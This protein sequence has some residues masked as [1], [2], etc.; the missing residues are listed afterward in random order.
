M[1]NIAREII[2]GRRLNRNDDLDMLLHKNLGEVCEGADMIR[3]SLCGNKADLCSIINGR[4][5]RCS[6]NCKFCAQSAHN[7]TNCDVHDFLDLSDIM[8]DCGK[9]AKKGVNRYSIV[10]S[11][12]A[13][14]GYDL[15]LALKAYTALSDRYPDMIFCA[16]FGL[17]SV[18]DMKRLKKAGVS[19]YH[20]NI[21]TSSRY[22]PKICTSHTYEDKIN[23][24]KRAKEA[25]LE[26]CSGGIFGMGETWQ[27]RIDMAL[28]LASFE[29]S[30][31]PL[32]FLLPIKGTPLENQKPLLQE[33]IVR[34]V[35]I[36][37]YLN[38]TAYIRIAAGRNYFQDGGAVLFRSGANAVLTGDMLTTIGSSTDYD[39]KML[40]DFGFELK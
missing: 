1:K 14:E 31:I 34:I 8:K 23:Q 18:D 12:R 27:D 30:S 29:I 16:S 32:N 2:N 26:V 21:E 25:G 20:T 19:M 7:N 33:E 9:M 5:G 13:M 22:F 24:I 28:L 10:T 35:A 17:M 39:K 37:R 4:S 15:N 40:L 38:P 11:G 3:K 36:F 6:E